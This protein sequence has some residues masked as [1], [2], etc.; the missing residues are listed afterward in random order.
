MREIEVKKSGFERFFGELVDFITGGPL[1][2]MC[3]AAFPAAGAHAA[4]KTHTVRIEGMMRQFNLQW[5][6]H[7][8]RRFGLGAPAKLIHVNP[9]RW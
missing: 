6:I 7:R 1:V 8:L 4:G 3:V 2:A 5:Q 9:P